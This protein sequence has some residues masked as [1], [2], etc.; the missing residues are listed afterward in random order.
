MNYFSKQHKYNSLDQYL[1]T[2]YNS[3]VFKIS[4]NGNFTCP[5][6]DG[7]KGFGGCIFCSAKG[8]GEFA[9]NPKDD[10]LKQFNTQK[11]IMAKKWKNGKYIIYFQANTNTYAPLEKLKTHFDYA[12]NLDPNIV[13]LSIGTRPDCLD[14][15]IIE[16]LK[17]LN[18]KIPVWVELGLQTSHS[19]T[20]EYLNLCYTL[21]DFKQAVKKLREAKLEVITHIING[22]PNETPE[23]MLETVMFLNTQDIQGL[24]IHSLFILNKTKLGN[25]YLTKPFKILTLDEYVSI[26]SK[27]I[28]LLNANIIIHRLTGDA[29]KDEL[30]EPLWSLKKLVVMNEIDKYMKINNL[31]QGMKK[32]L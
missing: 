16:Y 2:K 26:T 4:L 29:P 32:E 13:A 18:N 19:E 21:A 1:K 15:Q 30:I 14:D 5:N 8:S 22:L 27:Q 17:E 25:I 23:M 20:M 31:Y 6:R 10:L 24:K 7:S 12:I 9:G 3:K 28:T 11:E